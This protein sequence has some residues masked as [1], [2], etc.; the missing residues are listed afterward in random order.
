MEELKERSISRREFL[1][2]YFIPATVAVG[3]SAAVYTLSEYLKKPGKNILEKTYTN[4]EETVTKS[5]SELSRYTNFIKNVYAHSGDVAYAQPALIRP[6]VVD[7]KFTPVEEL[8]LTNLGEEKKQ[9]EGWTYEHEYRD[10]DT[11]EVLMNVVQGENVPAYFRVKYD[12]DNDDLYVQTSLLYSEFEKEGANILLW[13]D[14]KNDGGDLPQQDD[15]IVFVSSGV[16]KG[17]MYKGT[18]DGWSSRLPLPEDIEVGLSLDD[19]TSSPY[20]TPNICAEFKIPKRKYLSEAPNVGFMIRTGTREMPFYTD[21][22]WPAKEYKLLKDYSPNMF[23]DLIIDS[24]AVPVPDVQT[25]RIATI[26]SFVLLLLYG[27]KKR[28]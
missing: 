10:T 4:V 16:L 19:G 8:E 24:N 1:R 23:G 22:N 28:I 11:K 12:I 27:L 17:G 14:P 25:S 21:S 6:R 13:F 9:N 26:L 20:K 18:G 7:G 15:F 2:K 3:A 5:S